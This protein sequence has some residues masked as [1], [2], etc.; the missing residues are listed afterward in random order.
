MYEKS[1]FIYF[2]NNAILDITYDEI[3]QCSKALKS[4]GSAGPDGLPPVFVSKCIYFLLIT[5]KIIYQK[6]I[7]SGV[8]PECWKKSFVIPFFKKGDKNLVSDYRPISILCKLSKLFEET[9]QSKFY[10]RV[11]CL[12]YTNQHGFIN[13]Y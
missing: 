12:I 1:L 6:S 13:S 11:S 3:L 7:S 9:F 8:Y 10:S 2:N 5:L 4:T